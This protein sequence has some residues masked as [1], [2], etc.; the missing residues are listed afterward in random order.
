MQTLTPVI[1]RCNEHCLPADLVAPARPAGVVILA[2]GSGTGRNSLRNRFLADQLMKAGFA[3]VLVDL[4]DDDEAHDRHN[5]FDAEL[6]ASRLT[7]A[8]QWAR[9]QAMASP[10]PVA[11]FG[12]GIGA[13]AA[14]LASAREPDRVAALVA[15]AGRPDVVRFWLPRVKAP[16]LLIV[17]ER[18]LSALECNRQAYELLQ[19][20]KKVV[21]VPGA[22]HLFEETGTLGIAARH[23]VHWF[24]CHLRAPQRR[25]TAVQ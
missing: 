14:L 6:L 1:I 21:I 4:L 24:E 7:K 15:S 16:T 9:T 17:G 23:A 20:Q 22:S 12:Q 2:H 19:T 25:R 5:V 8:S 3:T 11:Y 10:L 18:D 13:T